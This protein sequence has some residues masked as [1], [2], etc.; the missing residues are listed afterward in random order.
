[1]MYGNGMPEAEQIEH[2]RSIA[3]D[4]RAHAFALG[5]EN[6]SVTQGREPNFLNAF[7]LG[8]LGGFRRIVLT[9]ALRNSGDD[10]ER[11]LTY[12]PSPYNSRPNTP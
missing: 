2:E 4:S 1:M 9:R 3:V 8:G 7:G 5:M 6:I 11:L 12:S 10:T